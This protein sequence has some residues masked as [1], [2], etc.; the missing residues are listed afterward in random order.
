MATRRVHE[1]MTTD[2]VTLPKDAKLIEAVGKL[3][4]N[5]ISSIVITDK[6]T[7]LGIITERDITRIATAT[8]STDEMNSLPVSNFMSKKPCNRL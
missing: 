1:L 2:V 8:S 7:P 6:Q 5:N 3:A 4:D